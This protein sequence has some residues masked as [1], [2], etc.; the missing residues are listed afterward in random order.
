MQTDESTA[1]SDGVNNTI[2]RAQPYEYEETQIR[3]PEYS[4]A[5]LGSAVNVYDSVR[6]ETKGS[7]T[8]NGTNTVPSPAGADNRSTVLPD[9]PQ[10]TYYSV[11]E[12]GQENDMYSKLTLK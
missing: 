8:Y 10:E 1:S 5:A 4:Y 9:V 11:C 6:E 2:Y 3:E 12:N 7:D